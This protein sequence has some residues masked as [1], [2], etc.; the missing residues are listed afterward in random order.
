M[1]TTG[2]P[3]SGLRVIAFEQAVAGPLATR[4]LADAGAEIIKIE[5]REGGDF[6][7]HYDTAVNGQSAYF[8]WLNRGKRS[9]AIDLKAPGADE[10]TR[11]LIDS[12]DVVLQNLAPG[13][14][15]RLG[16]GYDS[17]SA[18]KPDVIYCNISGYGQ[19]GPF[20]DKKAFDLLLQGESGLISVTGTPD[21]P[22]KVGISVCDISAGMYAFSS[23]LLALR[24][25][26][27]TGKGDVID[28]SMLE[29]MADW[30]S[31]FAYFYSFADRKLPRAGMRHNV[32]VPYGVYKC[33]DGLL[34]N[35]AVENPRQWARLCEVVLERPDLVNDERFNANERRVINRAELEPL[36]EAQLGRLTQAEAIDLLER[37]D[38]P[39]GRVND[40][41]SLAKHEQLE[42]RDRWHEFDSEAGA[43]KLLGHPMNL[44][45]M[46]QRTDRIPALGEDSDAVVAELGF[47]ESEIADFLERGVIGASS[48]GHH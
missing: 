38:I 5:R 34:V 31:A 14:L 17:V 48:S 36:I 13:A 15:D 35:M 40:V 4:H 1:T 11:R 23:V 21:F 24:Q 27:A 25:R 10:I 41:E 2:Y 32:I 18:K 7:R 29:C 45:S 28:I 30:M 44:A 47:S 43:L 46:P 20:R 12:A 8:V 39:N 26:D 3:L 22:A 19:D 16:F 33:G 42:A 9:L 37:A 6:G